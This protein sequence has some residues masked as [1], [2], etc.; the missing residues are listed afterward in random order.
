MRPARGEQNAWSPVFDVAPK[1][2]FKGGKV[3]SGTNSMH[4]PSALEDQ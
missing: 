1:Q 3:G 4:S 2:A